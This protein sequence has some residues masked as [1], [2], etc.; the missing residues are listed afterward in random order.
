MKIYID[1]LPK[2]IKDELKRKKLFRTILHEQFLFIIP[3]LAF[4]AILFNI[5]YLL[6]SEKKSI[7]RAKSVAE[8]QDNYQELSSYEEKFQ[9][10]NA[11]TENILKIQNKHF[12]WL[13]I[14]GKMSA[15]IPDGVTITDF[16]NKDFKIFLVGRAIN[17]DTLLG[18]KDKL[19]SDN[20][21]ENINVPLSNLV[22]KDNIDFQ[23][24]LAIKKDCL[25]KQQ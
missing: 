19:E 12:H 15:N 24:D 7:I 13:T 25:I 18:F 23:M 16:S 5:Y 9:Q 1:L 10:V 22:V 2:K 4:I 6:D 21:F 17:R 11:I 8:S 3:I 20:C 14:F